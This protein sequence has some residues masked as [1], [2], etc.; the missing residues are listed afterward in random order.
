MAS[1]SVGQLLVNVGA[2]TR[3]LTAGLRQ[4]QRQVSAF[5]QQ[6]GKSARASR[7]AF[8]GICA[9]ATQ[10]LGRMRGLPVVGGMLSAGG[11]LSA[12]AGAVTGAASQA[13]QHSPQVK[14][15]QQRLQMMEMKQG[16]ELG[17]RAPMASFLLS[18]GGFGVA[19]QV[20]KK[21]AGRSSL[22]K[23]ETQ[24]GFALNNPLTSLGFLQRAFNA[25][26]GLVDEGLQEFFGPRYSVDAMQRP[27][28]AVVNQ[29]IDDTQSV[30]KD[31]QGL[32]NAARAQGV[33]P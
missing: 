25:G 27:F 8:A 3:P 7:T 2:N 26:R 13:A 11:A 24:T 17:K 10:M 4:A 29:V 1:R 15:L 12:A 6:V 5:G 33:N 28:D 20:A 21:M 22:F 16:R 31:V 9:G 23:P 18:G 14:I 32:Q 30:L 19:G